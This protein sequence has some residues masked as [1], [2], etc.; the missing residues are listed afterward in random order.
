MNDVFYKTN[1]LY[2]NLEEYVKDIKLLSNE[3]RVEQKYVEGRWR[4]PSDKTLDFVINNI[5][6]SSDLRFIHRSKR[7]FQPE[8]LEAVFLYQPKEWY[9][10]W[11]NIELK[12]LNFFVNKYKLKKY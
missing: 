7:F 8:L 9:I 5:K 11:C 3:I 12:N 10:A 1:N 4:E 6:N 2:K